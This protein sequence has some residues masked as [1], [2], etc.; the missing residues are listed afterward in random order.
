MRLASLALLVACS[1]CVTTASV[2]KRDSHVSLPLL[3]G[4]AAATFFVTSVNAAYVTDYSV[5]ASIATGAAVMAA[6][7][8]VGCLLGGCAEL[9]P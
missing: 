5:G 2:V 6:D 8:A 3:F 7:F 4:T 1:G 9:R